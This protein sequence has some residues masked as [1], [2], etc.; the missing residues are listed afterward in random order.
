MAARAAPP[1]PQTAAAWR[2]LASTKRALLLVWVTSRALSFT[3]AALTMALGLLPSLRIAVTKFVIDGVVAGISSGTPSLALRW[4]FVE[5]G[6][7]VF[8]SAS[9]RAQEVAESFLATMLGHRVNVMILEKATHLELTDFEDSTLYDKLTRARREASRRPLSMAKRCLQ[10]MRSLVSLTAYG[11]LLVRFSG[12]AVALLLI[13]AVPLFVAELKFAG[14]AF[15]LSRRQTS[16]FREQIYLERLLAMAEPAKEVK[17]F[18]LGPWLLER[19]RSIFDDFFGATSSLALKQG[20]FGF[21]LEVLSSVGL[22]LAYAWVVAAA[23]GQQISLGEMTMYLLIFKEGQQAF[24]AGLKAISG[25]Y[26]DHLYLSNLYEFLDYQVKRSGGTARASYTPG[27]GVRFED[28]WFQYPGAQEHTIRGVSFHIPPGTRFALV[29]S[30]GSG[31][32][33]LIKLL[34]G[35]YRPSRGRILLDGRD[36]QD[37]DP[38]VVRS[39]VGAIFQDFVRYELTVGANIGVGEVAAVADEPRLARAAAKGMAAEFVEDWSGKYD[40]QLGNLF[41]NGRELSGGQWQKVALSRALMREKADVLVLDE[42]TA[43]MDAEAEAAIFERLASLAADQ[44]AILISH[45]FSTVRMADRIAVLQ[46]GRIQ[47]HGSHEDLLAL[48]GTYARLFHLQ[49]KGYQ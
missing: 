11:A 44:S 23:V 32:T 31:K 49:A 26:A 41:M 40:T 6:L 18:G 28:V 14:D 3:L 48:G 2:V 33:T 42:P 10:L 30:N 25:M 8:I 35:L 21:I 39:R 37:W 13:T 19:Y 22:Y 27:D 20:L 36:L 4:L 1:S 34:T 38:D 46:D 17:L 7:V 24:V 16:G 45:R 12:R 5:A 43:A 47:E 29:G 15:R 9:R